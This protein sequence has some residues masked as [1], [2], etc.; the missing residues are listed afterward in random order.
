MLLLCVAVV[1]R[2]PAFARWQQA[3]VYEGRYRLPP[4]EVLPWLALG[5]RE[6]AADLVW[7]SALVYFGEEVRHRGALRHVF[8]YAE[9]AITLDPWFRSA[10]RWA[11]TAGMY[12]PVEVTVED[13]ERAIEYLER[14]ARRFPDD[15]EMAWEL[16][17]SLAY[18]LAPRLRGEAARRAR[19]R[20]LEHLQAAVRLGAGPPWA[21]LSNASVLERLGQ[22]ERAARHIEEMASAVRDPEVRREL[23][24]RLAQLRGQSHAEALAAA[25]HEAERRHRR[26]FPYVPFDLWLLL[27]PR[28]P[29]AD[30]PQIGVGRD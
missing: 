25:L 16:G 18:E 1:L 12:R 22:A 29:H 6:A 23:L 7:V 27:G 4:P 15:G 8:D 9:A 24:D 30:A 20:G 26:E 2:A 3:E 13:I 10:Y 19:L 14:G 28:P 5:W 17:A 11:G 21:V